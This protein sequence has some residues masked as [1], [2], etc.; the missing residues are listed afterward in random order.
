MPHP[1]YW[2]LLFGPAQLHVKM[3]LAHRDRHGLRAAIRQAEPALVLAGSRAV[4]A[5]PRL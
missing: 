5:D 3:L 1:T 4:L 2:A